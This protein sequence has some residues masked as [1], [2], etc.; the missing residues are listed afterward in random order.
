MLLFRAVFALVIAG[1]VVQARAAC[2]CDITDDFVAFTAES[3]T[4][5]FICSIGDDDCASSLLW[6]LKVVGDS[7][8]IRTRVIIGAASK[9][10]LKQILQ[11]FRHEEP[12]RPTGSL[13]DWIQLDSNFAIHLPLP[14][15]ELL[16]RFKIWDSSAIPAFYWN[17]QERKAGIDVPWSRGDTLEIVA[18]DSSG[19]YINY[20][21]RYIYY[22]AKSGYLLIFTKN[23]RYAGEFDCEN[24]FLLLRRKNAI[25]P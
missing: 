13:N 20:E 16:A 4:A 7:P 22:F 12:F 10:T 8:T 1:L 21:I 9:N 5:F 24:G 18:I 6:R 17:R 2:D 14:T 19:F 3:D 25:K 23:D 11:T 15:A